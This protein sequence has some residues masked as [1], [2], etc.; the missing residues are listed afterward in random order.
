MHHKI[1][2]LHGYCKITF[3]FCFL[4]TAI[5]QPQ[6][7][8]ILCL[9]LFF[10]FSYIFSNQ[11][12][13]CLLKVIFYRTFV[14]CESLTNCIILTYSGASFLYCLF[15]S[16]KSYITCDIFSIHFFTTWLEFS[17]FSNALNSRI[18]FVN[19]CKKYSHKCKNIKFIILTVMPIKLE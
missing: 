14:S 18:L 6:V 17:V 1:D 2:V 15:F 19:V 4:C 9:A 16:Q 13:C 10:V 5:A 3:W 11:L 12:I 8:Q 7:L